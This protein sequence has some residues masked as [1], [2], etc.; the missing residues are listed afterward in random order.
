LSSLP[1]ICDLYAGRRWLPRFIV[2][3]RTTGLLAGVALEA[4]GEPM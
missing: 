3:P 2:G 4:R 1:T